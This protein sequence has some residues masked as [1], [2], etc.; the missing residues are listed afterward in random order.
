M[1]SP[2]LLPLPGGAVLHLLMSP[3]LLQLPGDAA[4]PHPLMSPPLVQLLGGA[5]LHLLPRH[6]LLIPGGAAQ[7]RLAVILKAMKCVRATRICAKCFCQCFLC[8]KCRLIK[9]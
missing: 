4:R 2:P 6:P 7:H 3:Q 1:M 8:N 5:V 9:M